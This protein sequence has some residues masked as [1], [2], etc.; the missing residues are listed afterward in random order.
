MAYLNRPFCGTMDK[1]VHARLPK[2]LAVKLLKFV[3]QRKMTQSAARQ[4]LRAFCTHYRL[5]P[6]AADH[7][8]VA[9]LV[10]TPQTWL[11][12]TP[13]HRQH[14][15]WVNEALPSREHSGPAS[16]KRS[17]LRCGKCKK[18]QVEYYE[19]QTR[20]ADEPMT[21]FAHCLHCGKR[22]TQ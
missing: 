17:L 22:W 13:Y 10:M 4:T 3:K 20:G 9:D 11:V 12:S 2:P 19:M 18:N 7:F 1:Y 6:S 14:Q 8:G 21:V 16:S 5:H 15:Q